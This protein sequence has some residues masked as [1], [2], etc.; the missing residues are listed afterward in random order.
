MRRTKRQQR[1]WERLLAKQA[2]FGR[3]TWAQK[4]AYWKLEKLRPWVKP[5][6]RSRLVAQAAEPTIGGS[7]DE[8]KAVVKAMFA[9]PLHPDEKYRGMDEEELEYW[10]QYYAPENQ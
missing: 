8:A 5:M 1:L 4:R 3:F 9:P 6:C 10:N 2:A 7:E